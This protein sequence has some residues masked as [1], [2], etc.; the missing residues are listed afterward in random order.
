MLVAPAAL[1]QLGL[2]VYRC[3]NLWDGSAS[4]TTAGVVVEGTLLLLVALAIRKP[5]GFSLALLIALSIVPMVNNLSAGSDASPVRAIV[6]VG[7]VGSLT[8]GFVIA[9]TARSRGSE[10]QHLAGLW[11]DADDVP[12]E[13]N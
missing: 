3:R 1:L 5:W 10:K 6:R 7:I 8:A 11:S 13:P 2:A 9:R 4:S 12:I